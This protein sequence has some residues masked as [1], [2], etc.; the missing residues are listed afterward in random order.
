MYHV[1]EAG[2]T[3]WC[4]V[5]GWLRGERPPLREVGPPEQ[6]QRGLRR[7]LAQR[8]PPAT[9][10]KQSRPPQTPFF[11]ALHL[12]SNTT[13]YHITT[14]LRSSTAIS[15]SLLPV[16][17]G[18][19]APVHPR[20]AYSHSLLVAAGEN[21]LPLAAPLRGGREPS[22]ASVVAHG[23][24]LTL[25]RF[26][27]SRTHYAVSFDKKCSWIFRVFFLKSRKKNELR[28]SVLFVNLG[29]DSWRFSI[30]TKP[31]LVPDKV[32]NV[33]DVWGGRHIFYQFFRNARQSRA[34]VGA[35]AWGRVGL[36]KRL[37]WVDAFS[38]LDKKKHKNTINS[39]KTSIK[40]NIFGSFSDSNC[41]TK[42]VKAP[43]GT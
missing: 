9:L 24:S 17:G 27:N 32:P 18:R 6:P 12:E 20:D 13:N 33:F 35:L 16:S 31:Y 21:N 19:V 8:R 41:G 11:V 29:P 3:N 38:R 34:R 2:H 7:S 37:G 23:C 1:T 10:R 39:L 40:W 22:L 5:V 14:S 42:P 25:L 28:F 15:P 4:H 36:G 30:C 26:S 43:R